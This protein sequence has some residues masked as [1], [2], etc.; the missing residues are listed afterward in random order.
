MSRISAIIMQVSKGFHLY[1]VH[2]AQKYIRIFAIN[3]LPMI[4]ATI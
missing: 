1:C 4:G 3:L 2:P